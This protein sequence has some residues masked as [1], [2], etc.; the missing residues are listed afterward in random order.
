MSS[1]QEFTCPICGWPHLN[2]DP[3]TLSYEI[4]PSCGV[5]FGYEAVED[6]MALRIL[7][8]QQGMKFWADAIKNPGAPRAPENWDPVEQLNKLIK[9]DPLAN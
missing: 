4:C 7:W 1:P 8:V 6:Y 5:E 2:K 9:E 3:T